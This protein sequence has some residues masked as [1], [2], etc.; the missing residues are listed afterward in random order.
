MVYAGVDTA[1]FPKEGALHHQVIAARPLGEGN[2][3]FISASPEWDAGRAPVGQRA[4]TLS[5]H[6]RMDAWWDL[7]ENDRD[8]YESRKKEYVAKM[9]AHAERALPGFSDGASF[10]MSGTPVTFERFTRRPFGWVGG[11]PQ[12]NLFRAWGPRLGPN[13]WMVGDS[14]FPGQSTAAV[15]LG[16]MRIANEILAEKAVE[17]SE[18]SSGFPAV[19]SKPQLKGRES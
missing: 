18:V 7:F 5:T 17:T 2:S 16:G 14:I 12:T 10:V 1:V 15:A 11:F 9:L 13:L 6:T 8:R 3:V 19:P 4:V